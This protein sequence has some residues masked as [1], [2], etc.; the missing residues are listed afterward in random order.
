MPP[1]GREHI[2]WQCGLRRNKFMDFSINGGALLAHESLDFS[3]A[4]SDSVSTASRSCELP[5]VC[6]PPVVWSGLWV[7]GAALGHSAPDGDE[8][9]RASGTL[10]TCN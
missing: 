3:A 1:P 6:A 10:M 9:W 5:G 2:D 4:S 7:V 8:Q